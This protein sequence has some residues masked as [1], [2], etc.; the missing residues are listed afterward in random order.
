MSWRIKARRLA[1]DLNVSRVAK[2]GSLPVTRR[3]VLPANISKARVEM[4]AW[5]GALLDRTIR[6]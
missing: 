2:F 1:S 5:T 6:K 3:Q 4:L